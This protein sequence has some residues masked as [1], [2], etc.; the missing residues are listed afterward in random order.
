VNDSRRAPWP[1]GLVAAV[2]VA[3]VLIAVVVDGAIS[4]ITAFTAGT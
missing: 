3:L 2:V 1:S 4:V